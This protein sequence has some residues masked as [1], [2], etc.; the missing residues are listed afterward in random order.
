MA[1]AVEQERRITL[2]EFEQRVA[3]AADGRR[4][5]LVDGRIVMMSN[6][7]ETHEQIVSNLGAPLKLA[8]D[9]RNCR[10]YLGG[11]RVQANDDL[12]R[13]DGCRP[14]IVVR[15]GPRGDRTWITDPVVVVEVLS[16]STMDVDRGRKLWFYKSLASV[17][18]IL[19]IYTDQMRVEHYRR[20][21]GDWSMEVLTRPGDDLV[22][23]AVAYRID[24]GRIYF[25]LP[26]G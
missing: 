10:T 4:L 2:A 15:C 18:H 21:D 26:I 5:E 19:L 6:P 16:P 24:L 13:F 20:T 22:L 23:D 11:M 3:A 12:G 1:E 8:M 9:G 17:S 25:D 7:T 14:D